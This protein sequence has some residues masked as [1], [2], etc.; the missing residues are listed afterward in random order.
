MTEFL[1]LFTG[2]Q[3]GPYGRGGVGGG[4]GFGSGGGRGGGNPGGG[5]FQTGGPPRSQGGFGGGFDDFG[6]GG[7][8]GGFAASTPLR[9]SG[10]SPPLTPTL[11]AILLS[12]EIPADLP[13]PLTPESAPRTPVAIPERNST[14]TSEPASGRSVSVSSGTATSAP[15]S[16]GGGAAAATVPDS[17][18]REQMLAQEN[19]RLQNDLAASNNAR[20]RMS[21]ALTERERARTEQIQENA[22]LQ[23]LNDLY[24]SSMK[25]QKERLEQSNEALVQARSAIE[26]ERSLLVNATEARNLCRQELE[27]LHATHDAT[28][29]ELRGARANLASCNEATELHE[30]ETRRLQAQLDD[31]QTQYAR[32]QRAYATDGAKNRTDLTQ[33]QERLRDAMAARQRLDTQHA[34]DEQKLSTLKNALNDCREAEKAQARELAELERLRSSDNQGS[35]E[36]IQAVRYQLQEAIATRDALQAEHDA[37]EQ[38][39]NIITQR[40]KY[41]RAAEASLAAEVGRLRQANATPQG[42]RTLLPVSGALSAAISAQASSPAERG[43]L[44]ALALN[45]VALPTTPTRFPAVTPPTT[46]AA[47]L[48]KEKNTERMAAST[49]SGAEDR[50]RR[51]DAILSPALA[52]TPRAGNFTPLSTGLIRTLAGDITPIRAGMESLGKSDERGLSALLSQGPSTNSASSTILS[53]TTP[54]RSPRTPDALSPMPGSPMAGAGSPVPFLLPG[55]PVASVSPRRFGPAYTPASRQSSPLAIEGGPVSA[56]RTVSAPA[57]ATGPLVSTAKPTLNLDLPIWVSQTANLPSP[58]GRMRPSETFS[59][60]PNPREGDRSTVTPRSLGPS[61]ASTPASAMGSPL[62]RQQGPPP[63]TEISAE[64]PDGEDAFDPNQTIDNMMYSTQQPLNTVDWSPSLR[65]AYLNS[66]SGSSAYSPN[67]SSPF[68]PPSPELSMNPRNIG[69]SDLQV[70]PDFQD[71]STAIEMDESEVADRGPDETEPRA[72]TIQ[73]IQAKFQKEGGV[74]NNDF[75]DA[76]IARVQLVTKDN[77]AT[78]YAGQVY[79]FIM[80]EIANNNAPW[81]NPSFNVQPPDPTQRAKRSASIAFRAALVTFLQGLKTTT[82][83]G[84][85]ARFVM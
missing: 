5:G 14:L 35:I 13:S 55:S 79:D 61:A 65:A 84:T 60:R 52:S 15:S 10:I 33:V 68:G 36:T 4:G 6:R 83:T 56:P 3:P 53:S 51:V 73:Q 44:G 20:D 30:G 2:T 38:E 59:P 23:Q 8:G 17:L 19:D 58:N 74:V 77:D 69:R 64:T 34:A 29:E 50:R 11:D 67:R 24:I 62:Q 40:L 85:S 70:K 26:N 7:N 42:P 31:V 76:L 21:T 47:R 37:D 1:R 22:R 78:D 27:Q 48:A 63:I 25:S 49:P 71:D 16:A 54:R 81:T 28:E 45:A 57:L 46:P 39:L 32:L 9:N 72:L 43:R 66:L 75:I 80:Q 12:S 82:T 41:S 18:E